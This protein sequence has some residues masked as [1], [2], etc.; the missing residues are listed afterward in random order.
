MGHCHDVHS[1]Q[2]QGCMGQLPLPMEKQPSHAKSLSEARP[3]L[4]GASHVSAVLDM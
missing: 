1:N 3:T 4:L 2:L